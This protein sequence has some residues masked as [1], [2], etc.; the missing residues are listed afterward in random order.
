MEEFDEDEVPPV[1]D[2]N[3][4]KIVPPQPNIHPNSNNGFYMDENGNSFFYDWE[5]KE[6]VS[7]D[8][9][10]PTEEQ[11]TIINVDYSIK[12]QVM[13]VEKIPK[14]PDFS[15]LYRETDEDDNMYYANLKREKKRKEAERKN[16]VLKKIKE[17]KNKEKNNTESISIIEKKEG[18]EKKESGDINPNPNKKPRGKKKKEKVNC[19]VYVKGLPQDISLDELAKFMEKYGGIIK[20]D[21]ET[22]EYKIKFYK[23]NEINTGEA[24]V[25][26]FLPES[27]QQALT[28]ADGNEI[29]EGF[30]VKV[31][32]ATFDSNKHLG[33]GNQAQKRKRK[34]KK[35]YDQSKELDWNEEDNRVHIIM[36]YMFTLIEAQKGGEDFFFDLKKEIIEELKELG[37]VD[38]VKIFERNPQGVVAVKFKFP[39]TAQRCVRI[40]NGRFFGGRKIEVD[41]YDEFTNY[42]VEETPEEKLKRQKEFDLWIGN[43]TNEIPQKRETSQKSENI[44]LDD[45]PDQNEEDDEDTLGQLKGI[46]DDD[47]S[48]SSSSD[49]SSD[50]EK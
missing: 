11:N 28:F 36:K 9:P 14:P 3:K 21:P 40:M 18:A 38:T 16:K 46:L 12:Q 1:L 49:D 20:K 10:M 19:S 30:V 4:T 48:N 29:R 47:F 37:P 13:P 7:F 5:K 34:P 35:V 31:E 50:E 44:T 33:E 24:L 26:Y 32:V 6:W 15:K 8:Q 25:T 23:N 41:F 42:N 22:R 39:L 43:T 2:Q 17:D 45:L 27:V